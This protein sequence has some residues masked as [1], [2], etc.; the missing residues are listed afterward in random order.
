M[1]KFEYPVIEVVE[2]ENQ[3]IIMASPGCMGETNEDCVDDE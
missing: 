1:K 3:D 2:L